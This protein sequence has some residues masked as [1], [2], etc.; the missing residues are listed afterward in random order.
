MAF[1]K[2][3]VALTKPKVQD[4]PV[5]GEERDGM[6][7]DGQTWVAKEVWLKREK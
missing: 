2:K 7:W 1:M 4:L 6:V 3:S 5:V